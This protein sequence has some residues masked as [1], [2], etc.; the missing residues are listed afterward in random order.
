MG[1]R[2]HYPQNA[3]PWQVEYF[4]LMEF[5][6]IAEKES[7]SDLPLKQVIKSSCERGPCFTQRKGVPLSTKT[8]ETEKNPKKQA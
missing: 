4:K 2:T 6:K 5:E 3:A 7:Y 1:F 8:K